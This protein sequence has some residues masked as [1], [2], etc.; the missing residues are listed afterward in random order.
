MVTRQVWSLPDGQEN[1][2]EGLDAP[3]STEA[4]RRLQAELKAIDVCGAM[5]ECVNEVCP[6][7]LLG[8]HG[9]DKP[10]VSLDGTPNQ[11]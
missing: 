9:P 8:D 1:A 4:L 2:G 6:C 10:F 5:E 11:Q 3:W 7:A